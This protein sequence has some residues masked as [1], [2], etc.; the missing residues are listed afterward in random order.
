M[1]S[2]LLS[3]LAVYRYAISPMLGANCR[4]LPSC[5]EYATEAIRRHGSLRGGWLSLRRIARCHPW[6]PGGHDPVP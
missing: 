1:K 5:S 6:N 2:L 3:V 4:F